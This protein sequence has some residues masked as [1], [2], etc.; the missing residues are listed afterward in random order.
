MPFL[1]IGADIRY[2]IRRSQIGGIIHCKSS[3]AAHSVDEL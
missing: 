3:L 2:C 1:Q